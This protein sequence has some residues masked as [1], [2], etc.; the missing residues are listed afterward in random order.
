MIEWASL[1]WLKIFHKWCNDVCLLSSLPFLSEPQLGGTYI[2]G[3]DKKSP[4]IHLC[5][6]YY[7][8]EIRSSSVSIQIAQWHTADWGS[9]DKLD[10]LDTQTSVGACT[11]APDLWIDATRLSEV[12]ECHLWPELVFFQN[13]RRVSGSILHFA[14]LISTV[15]TFYLYSHDQACLL[16]V[17]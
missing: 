11:G 4:W 13:Y 7:H 17:S 5:F 15:G 16:Y 9:S 6:P 12:F 8:K 3:T 10:W 1:M 2:F 14:A